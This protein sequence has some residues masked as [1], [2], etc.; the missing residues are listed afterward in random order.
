MRKESINAEFEQRKELGGG[1]WP[2]L[3][4]LFEHSCVHVEFADI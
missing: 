1:S 4:P 3:F 2:K